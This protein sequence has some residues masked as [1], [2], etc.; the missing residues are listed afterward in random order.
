MSSRVATGY[1]KETT[2]RVAGGHINAM[3][4][5]LCVDPADLPI[6]AVALHF[7]GRSVSSETVEV[8][9]SSLKAWRAW[10]HNGAK[11]FADE[12]QDIDYSDLDDA[13]LQAW[14]RK[15]RRRKAKNTVDGYI[16]QVRLIARSAGCGAAELTAEDVEAHID[17]ADDRQMARKGELLRANTVRA[18]LAAVRA[19]CRFLRKADITAGL[20]F[21][22]D[23]RNSS[24][25]L[26]IPRESLMYL[27]DCAEVEMQD[28]DAEV[29]LNAKRVRSVLLQQSTMGHRIHEAHATDA[30]GLEYR[31]GRAYLPLAQFKRGQ[32]QA[33]IWLRCSAQVE[34]DIRENWPEGGRI[35][36]EWWT[37][38]RTR[39]MLVAFGLRHGVIFHTHQLR[40]RF[41]TDM[42]RATGNDIM[43]VKR[44]M[45]HRSVKTTERYIHLDDC[46]PVHDIA[47]ALG[48]DLT[49]RPPVKPAPLP[50]P[51]RVVAAESKRWLAEIQ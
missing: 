21:E 28:P 24:T 49:S 18:K 15:M 11:S 33:P 34:A 31:D 13:D 26:P 39:T 37:V 2:A 48:S 30:S 10:L 7:A 32:R 4:R 9:S 16:R 43:A 5:R 36:P 6:D 19:F 22:L 50:G 38:S 23:E 25:T 17:E 35:I 27:L 1:V 46:D 45:R 40:A 44:Y 14:A 51:R 12:R 29:A 3:A 20:D 8:Y 47:Y 42:Y 41:A